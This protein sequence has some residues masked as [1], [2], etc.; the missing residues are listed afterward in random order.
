MKAV[1]TFPAGA[2]NCPECGKL[3]F[4]S[5]LKVEQ[6]MSP[7]DL[8]DFYNKLF[9]DEMPD[10]TEGYVL[11]EPEEVECSHCNAEFLTRTGDFNQNESDAS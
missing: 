2:F 9:V 5:L 7:V 4:Y 10:D 6:I 1:E 8:G 11:T 3:S